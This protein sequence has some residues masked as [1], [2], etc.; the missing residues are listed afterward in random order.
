MR[1]TTTYPR[2]GDTF[3]FADAKALNGA[4]ADIV[5]EDEDARVAYPGA[6]IWGIAGSWLAV[7]TTRAI[8]T[9]AVTGESLGAAPG[10]PELRIP[11]GDI[12]EISRTA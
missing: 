12:T 5:T 8:Y 11:F 2:H 9:D 1:I 10:E 7:R 6:V 4:T 3:S